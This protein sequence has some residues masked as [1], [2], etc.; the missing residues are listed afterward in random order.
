MSSA[1]GNDAPQRT[2]RSKSASEVSA[3]KYVGASIEVL[4]E[5]NDGILLELKQAP[6]WSTSSPVS[7]VNLEIALGSS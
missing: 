2:S 3:T 6:S 1:S 4:S 7:S 5:R